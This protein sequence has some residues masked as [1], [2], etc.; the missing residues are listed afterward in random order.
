MAF[1]ANYN[2]MNTKIFQRMV[3]TVGF[4]WCYTIIYEIV[5]D[6]APAP[7]IFFVPMILI[8]VY[9]LNNIQST[10]VMK[11]ISIEVLWLCLTRIFL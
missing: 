7:E 6:P 10:E 5:F 1:Y 9:I 2:K 3:K 8:N 4:M 11:A